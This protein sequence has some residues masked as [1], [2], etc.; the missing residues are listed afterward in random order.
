MKTERIMEYA[1]VIRTV[2]QYAKVDEDY[3]MRLFIAKQSICA[4]VERVYANYGKYTFVPTPEDLEWNPEDHVPENKL[5]TIGE[6]SDIL[7]MLRFQDMVIQAQALDLSRTSVQA[8]IIKQRAMDIREKF[9]DQQDYVSPL[10]KGD[11]DITRKK[12][13]LHREKQTK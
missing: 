9:R 5:K 1:S 10:Q 3:T 4:M 2:D 11:I 8:R 7:E 13:K 6:L 12:L